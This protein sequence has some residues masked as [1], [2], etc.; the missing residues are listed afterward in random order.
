MVAIQVEEG[1]GSGHPSEPQPPPSTAQPTN[2]EP[3]LNVVSSSHQKTQPPRQALK[4]V[5]ELPQTS[6]PIPNVPDEAV[7]EEWDDI[8]E[9]ATTT[10]AS[11]EAE[12]ASGTINRTQSTT[13]PNVPLPQ[14]IGA[15]GSPRC[16]EV[17]WGSIAQTRSERVPTPP[18]DLPIPKVNTPGSVEGSIELKELAELYITLFKKVESLE[19]DLQQTK[20]VYNTTF[21]R[22]INKVKK[23]ERKIKS[24]TARRR[25]R[26]VIS[27]EDLLADDIVEDPSKQGR[28]FQEIDDDV[29]ITL[30]QTDADI[31]GRFGLTKKEGLLTRVSAQGEAQSQDS[32]EVQLGVLSATKA[33][34]DGV[35]EG[36]QT[37]NRRRRRSVNTGSVGVSTTSILLSTVAD[38]VSD[39]GASRLDSTADL[40]QER[41][42]LEEAVRLQEELD[43][44]ERQRM[45]R[46]HEATH[47]ISNIDWD[48]VKAQI[49]AD[50]D[51]AQR[52]LEEE[53]E[54]GY[55]RKTN[56]KAHQFKGY[57]FKEIKDIFSKTYKQVQSFIPTETEAIERTSELEVGGSQVEVGSSKRLVEEELQQESTK[58][59]KIDE[60]ELSKEDLQQMMMIVLVEAMNIIRVGNHKEVYKYFVDMLNIFDINDLVKLWSLVKERFSLAEPSEDMERSLWVELKRLF[61]PDNDD[62]LWKLQRYMH[63]PLTWKLYDTCGVH[64]VSSVRGH[65]IYMLVEKE[66]P[67]SSAVL[68]LMLTAKL[69]VDEE[70]EMANELLR[71]IFIMA[72]QSRR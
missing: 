62:T 6:E 37:Y 9:R 31:Q 66:N 19:A 42:G 52:M 14:G 33:L 47:L 35:K 43:E 34:T 16:Q 63:D 38:T 17:M 21:Q 1:E 12:Q 7:Y 30:V 2:E 13:M 60:D 50:E 26:M 5:T 71:K 22:L 23:L 28:K 3:F 70:S 25:S 29:E 56:W 36:V 41:L 44:E 65:D 59:Q 51:L 24:T 11:L 67:L 10:A 57:S 61:E 53:R 49:W 20:K 72:N 69:M 32:P 27:D 4:R 39:V 40:E 54:T 48:D 64:H 46:V 18:C 8:V 55:Y 68:T 45:A 58:K 15:G